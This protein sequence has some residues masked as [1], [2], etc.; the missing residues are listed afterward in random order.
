MLP[1]YR[2]RFG[3]QWLIP[4]RS[5]RSAVS[6]NSTAMRHGSLNANTHKDG[7]TFFHLIQIRAN[8]HVGVFPLQTALT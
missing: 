3:L 2:D 6:E 5:H 4:R 8:G 7:R 1:F